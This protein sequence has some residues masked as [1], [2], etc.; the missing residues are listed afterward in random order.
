ME[1]G[2]TGGR[3]LKRHSRRF[4]RFRLTSIGAGL[5][6]LSAV[7]LVLTSSTFAPATIFPDVPA[8]HPYADAIADLAE[9]KIIL[10][11]SDGTYRP[12]APVMRQQFAKLIVLTLGYPVSEQN[13]SFFRDV[14][15]SGPDSLYPDNYVA[16]AA[17]RGITLGTGPQTFAPYRDISRFQ[18]ISMTVR[19]VDDLYPGLLDPPPSDFTA[20]WN[21]AQSPDH[22]QNARRAEYN[23]LLA[24]MPLESLDPWASMPRGEVAQVLQNLLAKLPNPTTTTTGSTTTTTEPK[25]PFEEHPY[26]DMPNLIVT[27]LAARTERA[28]Q[29]QTVTFTATVENGG[30][31][32]FSGGI[33]TFLVD[34]EPVGETGVPAL[35]PGSLGGIEAR[36]TAAGPGRHVVRAEV[37]AAGEDVESDERDNW[38]ECSV[39]VAGEAQPVPAVVVDGPDFEELQISPG[40]DLR[41][42]LRVRNP[43]Y[44]LLPET[45]IRFLID[46]ELVA[47]ETVD[48]LGPGGWQDLQVPWSAVMAGDHLLKVEMDLD[49]R[50]PDPTAAGVTVYRA[51]VP[52]QGP[53]YSY[54]AARDKWASMGPSILASD[55]AGRME[56]LVFDPKNPGIVYGCSEVGGIW[57]TTDG[58]GTWAPIGDKLSTMDFRRIAVDPKYPGV[59]YAASY[60]NGV[61][62]SIDAGATWTAFALRAKDGSTDVGIKN[63][64]GLAVLHPDPATNEVLVY[65]ACEAGV[66]RYKDA[67]PWKKV[68]VAGEWDV[69]LDGPVW[70]MVVHPEDP[71]ILWAS[72]HRW[73]NNKQSL[74]FDYVASTVM[75]SW[76]TKANWFKVSTGL[77]KQGQCKLAF[78][79]HQ[80]QYVLY[81]SISR[82]DANHEL[83]IYR[84]PNGGISWTRVVDYPPSAGDY[85]KSMYNPFIRVNPT[86]SNIVYVAGTR[87]YRVDVTKAL[88]GAP[89]HTTVVKAGHPDIKELV[90]L[91]NP[92]AGFDEA[93]WVL[94]DG[95]V[96]QVKNGPQL[97]MLTPRNQELRNIQLYDMDSAATDSKLMIGGTQDNQTIQYQGSAEWREIGP[98]GDGMYALISPTNSNRMYAQYQFMDSTARTDNGKGTSV[99]WADAS[100]T[101]PNR[102]PHIGDGYIT[103]DPTDGNHLLGRGDQLWETKNGGATWAKAGPSPAAGQPP[104]RGS[105]ARVIFRPGTDSQTWMAGTSAGELW[106]HTTSGWNRVF[107]HKGAKGLPDNAA[108]R[109]MAFAPTDN[110]VLYVLFGTGDK[111]RRLYRFDLKGL[112]WVDYPISTQL[113][114]NVSLKVLCG[115]AYKPTVVYVGTS[116][117]VFRGERTPGLDY[118]WKPYNEGLPL[119]VVSDLLVDK[120]S[121]ELRAATNG[122]GAWGIKTGP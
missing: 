59:I 74:V 61:F 101:A 51:T 94:S 34:G 86:D 12:D 6:L 35:G 21:P 121:G 16:V 77:P 27:E 13:V 117:G 44:A 56:D 67:N 76:G 3:S 39:W 30:E 66:L 73:T 90:F 19:A 38:A 118:T 68:S 97:Q 69:I 72:V 75:G 78:F 88:A 1:S 107:Q 26:W 63:P 104:V 79:A 116:A 100:G 58:G 55:N 22:G 14:E 24:L 9:R 87:L 119:V 53:L 11:Y 92:P 89:D 111:D 80:S 37:T 114:T 115:D 71:D 84:S 109:S 40:D 5:L 57:K 4:A 70:D 54:P 41:L 62:K 99:K 52:G 82:P 95:G 93:F 29:G 91:E 25:E 60:K 43:S 23:G 85:W 15:P 65:L 45:P 81:A 17:A 42:T 7:V 2:G 31:G 105:I 20:T 120:T 113:P 96:W 122:R 18:V 103:I 102:L 36:W 46:G 98:A 33:V 48:Q 110:S 83:A 64:K 47:T 49:D 28:A 108:V 112:N 8:D 50:F 106:Y 10:G 32:E